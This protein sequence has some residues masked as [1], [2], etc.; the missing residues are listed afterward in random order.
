MYGNS[1]ESR[2]TVMEIGRTM[3]VCPVCLTKIPAKKTVGD[4]GNIYLENAAGS[5]EVG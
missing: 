5:T 3:S 4:D 2:L 1:G